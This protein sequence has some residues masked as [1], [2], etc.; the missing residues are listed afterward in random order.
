MA[1]RRLQPEKFQARAI[2]DFKDKVNWYAEA[3]HFA[4]ELRENWAWKEDGSGVGNSPSMQK[5]EEWFRENLMCPACQGMKFVIK[6]LTDFS[7]HGAT[8]CHACRGTG[9]RDID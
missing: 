7:Q 9:C 6:P 1:E 5:I 3:K 8:R 4:P 2:R